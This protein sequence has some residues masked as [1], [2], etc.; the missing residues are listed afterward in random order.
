MHL[1]IQI[2]IGRHGFCLDWNFLWSISL[3]CLAC[4]RD[5]LA[6][7]IKLQKFLCSKRDSNPF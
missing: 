3:T 6:Y 1:E 7:I 5:F 2:K 4:L